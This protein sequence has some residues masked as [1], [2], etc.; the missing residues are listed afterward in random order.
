MIETEVFVSTGKRSQ[1]YNKNNIS[2][3]EK[4]C[5]GQHYGQNGIPKNKM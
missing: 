3:D 1:V 4:H 5:T 2:N